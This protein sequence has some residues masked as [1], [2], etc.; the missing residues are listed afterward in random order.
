[1][2]SILQ[3]TFLITLTLFIFSC[4]GGETKTASKRQVVEQ[5]KG[6]KLPQIPPKFLKEL[7]TKCEGIE[8]TY[9]DHPM[10][11]ST[12]RDNSKNFL[13]FIQQQDVYE[14]QMQKR[15]LGIM[16]Y[17][18]EGDIYLEAEFYA[19][20]DNNFTPYF[21]FMKDKKTYYNVMSPEGANV[22]TNPLRGN[23]QQR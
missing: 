7:F 10:S 12:Q 3:Y 5:P 11:M 17:N 9:Y 20:V 4:G 21:K 16:S 8:V 14:H 18:I 1:M 6:K 23:I 15:A 13:M 19:D 2:Q 22:F